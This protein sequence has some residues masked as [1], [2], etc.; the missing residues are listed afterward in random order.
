MYGEAVVERSGEG[1]VLRLP[2]V[3]AVVRLN[4]TSTAIECC[5]DEA[6]RARLRDILLKHLVVI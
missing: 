4:P 1:V 3:G 2:G 6:V 5:E